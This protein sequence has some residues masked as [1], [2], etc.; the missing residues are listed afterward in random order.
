MMK[1]KI[2]GLPGVLPVSPVARLS[3]AEP[4]LTVMLTV[5]PTS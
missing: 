4:G 5:A 1:S 3:Q 2:G